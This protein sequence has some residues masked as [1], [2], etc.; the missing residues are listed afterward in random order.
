MSE[1]KFEKW[2][3]KW[4]YE[5]Y[6]PVYH[7]Y[8]SYDDGEVVFSIDI[9]GARGGTCWDDSDPESYQNSFSSDETENK[10]VFEF[11]SEFFPDISFVKYKS[12]C[13][14]IEKYEHRENEY[15]GNYTDY[16]IEKV[17][18]A[19]LVEFLEGGHV[20]ANSD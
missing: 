2:S 13:K 14:L 8:Y 15:Y 17:K 12:I 7:T 9:G 5:N 4:V 1:T 20:K 18:V 19:D 16:K 11:V 10:F 3:K 6:S